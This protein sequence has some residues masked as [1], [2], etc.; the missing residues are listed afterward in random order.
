MTQALPFGEIRPGAKPLQAFIQPG[1]IQVAQ[2]PQLA[3]LPGVK[4]IST[5]QMAGT[6]SV[7]GYN[8][9][10]QMAEALGPFNKQFS[11]TAQ[12]YI[13]NDARTKIGE[14]RRHR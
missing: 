12:K 9:L 7:Q 5:Q 10:A 13:V 11:E 6:S 2:A 3:M 1:K 4:G 14:Q 8:Q